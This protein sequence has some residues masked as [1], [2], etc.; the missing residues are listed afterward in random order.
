MKAIR[1]GLCPHNC[2][3]EEGQMGLCRARINRQGAVVA[4]NYGRITSI[5]LDPIEKKP[6]YHFYPGS[7]ILS[8]GSYGCN[9]F[10]SFC[11][12]YRISTAS[13][14]DVSYRELSP[15]QLVE[16]AKQYSPQGNIGLA[17]TYNEPLVGYEY[18]VDC[19]RLA[20]QEGQK[21]VVVTNGCFY[22]EQ[23][24]ALWPLV[25]AFNI[26]LKGFTEAFYKK[27]GGELEVVKQFIARA[28]AL[29]HVE[30]TTL[31]IPDENDGLE[32]M[33]A[34]SAWIASVDKK[35]P[36][37]I[38]RFFP[39]YKMVDKS[40]TDVEKIMELQKIAQENLEFVYRGNC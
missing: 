16:T 32:E 37:H 39:M 17:F 38:S 35:I 31:I 2:L 8:V 10:C 40:P 28:A 29:S 36:L 27:M 15:E 26:D 5:A 20:K 9:L 34:L 33:R 24:E 12:N 3:L 30:V 18:I 25:D 4:E 1:C 6:L 19:A 14:K 13:A 21:V 7:K 22:T 23:L 11:Q